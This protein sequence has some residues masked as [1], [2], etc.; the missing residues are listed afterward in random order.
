MTSLV[1]EELMS[2]YTLIN[3]R[4]NAKGGPQLNRRNPP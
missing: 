3:E 1:F 4:R 2:M